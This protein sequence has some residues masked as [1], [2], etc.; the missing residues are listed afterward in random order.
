MSKYIYTLNK[1][2]RGKSYDAEIAK[3]TIQR[4]NVN[5]FSLSL[6][7]SHVKTNINTPTLRKKWFMKHKA[8]QNKIVIEY[9]DKGQLNQNQKKKNNPRTT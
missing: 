1:A 3:V 8:H 7:R 2:K 9:M 6:S 4:V 5:T